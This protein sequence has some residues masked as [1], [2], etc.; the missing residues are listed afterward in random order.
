MNKKIKFRIFLFLNWI[1]LIW[2]VISVIN[3]FLITTE[4]I[5]GAE[6]KW[7]VKCYRSDGTSYYC[8]CDKELQT[9]TP[10]IDSIPIL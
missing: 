6:P 4:T 5:N 8:I 2:M 9:C 1:V 3:S 7:G 10:C